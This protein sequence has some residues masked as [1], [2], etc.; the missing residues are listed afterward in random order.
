MV[1]INSRGG[2]NLWLVLFQGPQI[3]VLCTSVGLFALFL[4]SQY[5]EIWRAE[6]FGV[7]YALYTG[8]TG[9]DSLSR[10]RIP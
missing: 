5:L 4:Y 8:G 10:H 7:I 1:L 9:F 2:R 3:L 6:V